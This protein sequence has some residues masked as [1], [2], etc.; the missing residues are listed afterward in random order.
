MFVGHG[1]VAFALIAIGGRSLGWSRE[2]TLSLAALAFAFATLPD[3][4]IVYAPVGLLGGASGVFAAAEAFWRT[5]NVVHRGATHSLPVGVVAA[6]GFGVWSARYGESGR[7]RRVTTGLAVTVLGGGVLA[8]TALSGGLVGVVLAVFA[9]VGA[10][11]ATVAGKRGIRPRAVFGAALLGTVSHPFGDL[12]TGEPPGML[13][14]FEATLVTERVVLHPDPTLHLIGAFAIELA[15][16]WLAVYAAFALYDR[17]LR[18]HVR[19]R[20][21]LGFGYAAAAVVLPAPTLAASYHFVFSVLALGVVGPVQT[22]RHDGHGG[23]RAVAARRLARTD[24][25]TAAVTGLTAVTLG[26]AGY[27]AVYLLG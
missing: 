14:P 26:V 12:F 1:L 7:S 10:G 11:I 25:A 21:A 17:R 24:A 8:A 18:D 4:D 16:V 27:A 3:V 19:P 13:Y 9:V 23:V 20:A 5:G 22:T 15:T 6:V 2:R